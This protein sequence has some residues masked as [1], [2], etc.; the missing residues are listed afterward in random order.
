MFPFG[1]QRLIRMDR[2][3]SK[4]GVRRYRLHS[5]YSA[6]IA[7]V[8]RTSRIHSGLHIDND[9]DLLLIG[10]L[11]LVRCNQG[12]RVGRGVVDKGGG[13]VETLSA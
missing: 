3:N 1:S 5:H 2:T 6:L 9:V 4:N 8:K 7:Q 13:T 12:V 11:E 10:V